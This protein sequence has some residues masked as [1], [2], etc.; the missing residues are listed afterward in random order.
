MRDPS[1]IDWSTL[2]SATDADGAAR[3]DS[4]YWRANIDPTELYVL[5]LPG[6]MRWRMTAGDNEFDN[7]VICGTWTDSGFNLSSVEGAVM[8]GLSAAKFISGEP[9]E[10]VGGATERANIAS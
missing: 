4:Q 3:F 10:I 2:H 1:G 8:S 6:T 7:L 5:S 9:I